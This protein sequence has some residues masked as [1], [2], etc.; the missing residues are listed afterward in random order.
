MGGFDPHTPTGATPLDPA[1]FGFE[2]PGWN[3]ITSTAY[4]AKSLYDGSGVGALIGGIFDVWNCP[5][6]ELSISG[7]FTGTK[8]V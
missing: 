5:K 2:D 3:R 7:I 6:V 1:Y 4:F 8:R